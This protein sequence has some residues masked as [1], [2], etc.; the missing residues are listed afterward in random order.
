[1]RRLAGDLRRDYKLRL[2]L[3]RVCRLRLTGLLSAASKRNR[4]NKKRRES[5]CVSHDSAAPRAW[6]VGNHWLNSS[7]RHAA[8]V[9][10]NRARL[11]DAAGDIDGAAEH[12]LQLKS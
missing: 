6:A 2:R 4:R 11:Y 1:M 8:I 3:R 10:E 7:R 9:S 12:L 5:K